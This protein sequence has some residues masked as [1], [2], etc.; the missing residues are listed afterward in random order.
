MKLNIGMK[1]SYMCLQS[2]LAAGAELAVAALER[3][4]C[5][6]RHFVVVE[7]LDVVEPG[8]T[9]LAEVWLLTSVN[10]QVIPQIRHLLGLIGAKVT[11][12]NIASMSPTSTA[13]AFR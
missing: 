13:N 11:V 9:L 6:V 12:V 5:Q 4:F 1:F 8:A 7:G 2:R 10:V 3:L